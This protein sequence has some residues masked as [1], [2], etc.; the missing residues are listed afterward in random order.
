VTEG[1]AYLERHALFARR[2]TDGMRRIRTTGLVA[3]AFVHRTSRN[4]DPQLHTHVLAANAVLGEDGRWSASDARGLYAHART[5]GFVYQASLRA[6]L[7]ESLGVAFGPVHRGAAEIEG[8]DASVLRHFS[9]R[10]AEIEEYLFIHGG[11][12]GRTAELAALAT[13]ESSASP[14][15]RRAT[16]EPSSP[17]NG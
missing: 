9:T 5:A 15:W 11:S 2:G 1:V 14:R 13:M 8:I 10:R 17:A 4:G 7:V 12:S 3:A 16:K 6:G